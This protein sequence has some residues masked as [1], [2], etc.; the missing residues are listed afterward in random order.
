M[1]HRLT[2][3]EVVF[4]ELAEARFPL[5]QAGLAEAGRDARDRDAFVLVREVVELLRDV[6]PE[7]GVGEGVRELV[8]FVH[9][10]YLHWLDGRCR[11]AVD[12][13]GLDRLVGDDH[14]TTSGVMAGPSYYLQLPPQRVWGTPTDHGPPE[15]LD[16]CFVIPRGEGVEIVAVFGLHPGRD[17]LTV[18]AA[19]GT[20]PERLLR[21]DGTPL[22]AP[23]LEGGAAAG[24]W[25][26][27]GEAELLELGYRCHGWLPPGGA[28]PGDM[29][30][31]AR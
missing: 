8:G 19:A 28:V 24:L 17:G 30:V 22:F 23:K 5:L 13:A 11:V 12:R 18:V 4:G 2:P 10:C 1:D 6:A 9:A 25:Q 20:R 3:F 14:R 27:V 16:G 26:V 21:E 31:R 7:G 15:P 29:T